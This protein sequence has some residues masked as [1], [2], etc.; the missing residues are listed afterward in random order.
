MN[1]GVKMALIIAAGLIAAVALYLYFS[2][3]HSCMRTMANGAAP[4]S[5]MARFAAERC[6]NSN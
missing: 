4:D 1:N 5:L 3:Y 2:P 6:A